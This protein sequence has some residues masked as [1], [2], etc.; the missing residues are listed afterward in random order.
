MREMKYVT[1]GINEPR[2]LG[3]RLSYYVA[4]VTFK[5]SSIAIASHVSELAVVTRLQVLPSALPPRFAD[6]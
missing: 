5:T 4:H 1:R 2:S 3:E 6:I